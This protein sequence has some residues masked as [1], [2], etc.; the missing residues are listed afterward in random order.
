MRGKVWHILCATFL[1]VVAFTVLSARAADTDKISAE[2]TKALLGTAVIVDARTGADW[3]GSTLKIQ[4][5]IRGSHPDIKEWTA[6]IPK[7]ATIIVYCA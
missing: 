7:D 6:T 5:A 3:S 4:G 2:E 1:F